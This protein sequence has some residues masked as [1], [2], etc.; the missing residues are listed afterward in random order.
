MADHSLQITNGG[1]DDAYIA[2]ERPSG[3]GRTEQGRIRPRSLPQTFSNL[4]C[5][6]LGPRSNL[7]RKPSAGLAMTF[8]WTFSW[9]LFL[10]PFP[11][12]FSWDIFLGHF[13]GA[14]L[15]PDPPCGVAAAIRKSATSGN[16]TPPQPA[17][18]LPARPT[19]QPLG[20]AGDGGNTRTRHFAQAQFH[21]DGNELLD[22]GRTP[23]DL[24]D[25]VIS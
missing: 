16:P 12:T 23:R 8:S 15:Q 6:C 4:H 18:A 13:R 11:G 7:A 22:L 14:R 1:R 21:H 24:E 2:P 25:E 3:S 10:G 17:H 20:A 5:T 19:S 9:D